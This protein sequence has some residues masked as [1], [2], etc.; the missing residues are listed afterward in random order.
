MVLYILKWSDVLGKKCSKITH[1]N[2]S[3]IFLYDCKTHLLKDICT[4]HIQMAV[5]QLVKVAT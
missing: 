3:S 1:S 2:G 4:K 5:K